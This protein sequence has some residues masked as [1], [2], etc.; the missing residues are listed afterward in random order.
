M[1]ELL[2]FKNPLQIKPTA[3]IYTNLGT[4]YFLRE[5]VSRSPYHV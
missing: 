3:D 1:M 5:E 4:G 2:R